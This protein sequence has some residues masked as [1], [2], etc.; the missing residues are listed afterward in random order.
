[1]DIFEIIALSSSITAE[2]LVGRTVVVEVVVVVVVVLLLN[3][4][5]VVLRLTGRTL[6]VVVLVTA[7][8][9]VVVLAGLTTGLRVGRGRLVVVVE[10][11]GACLFLLL[12]GFL[13]PD[14]PNRS[15]SRSSPRRLKPV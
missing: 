3:G 15:P 11:N 4:R 5:R 10:A 12:A 6:I 9:R 1:M 14:E 2:A 7:G 13:E 8:R